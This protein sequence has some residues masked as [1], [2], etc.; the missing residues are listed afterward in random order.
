MPDDVFHCPACRAPLRR[1]PAVAAGTLAQCPR[2]DERFPVPAEDRPAPP[3][4]ADQPAITDRPGRPR[5]SA[6]DH[7]DLP[8][9]RDDYDEDQRRDGRLD[10]GPGDRPGPDENDDDYY[11]PGVPR[12]QRLNTEYQVD[13]GE[14]M[15]YAKGHWGAM[16]GPCIGYVILAYLLLVIVAVVP[17]IGAFGL[18]FM[19]PP[20]AAG[21]T[22]VALRQLQGRRWQFGD[23]FSGFDHWG[24]LV[25]NSFLTGL[26]VFVCLLPALG[27]FIFGVMLALLSRELAAVLVIGLLLCVPVLI[28]ALLRLTFFAWPL[29]IDRGYGPLEAMQG[30]WRLTAKHFWPLLGVALVCLLI[31]IGGLI[32]CGVGA[33][34]T[35]PFITLIHAAGYL[36][37]AGRRPPLRGPA[38][39]R[40]PYDS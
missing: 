9:L 14:W 13:L 6:D 16:V 32:L 29:I 30:S 37:V 4:P 22:V 18:L 36:L 3:P 26:L 28:W 33:L 15:D 17:C 5:L 25:G 40:D 24:A 7:L 11:R 2:C 27:L 23:F 20:V 19:T 12:H 10:D 21:P 34:F 35:L 38:D 8:R 1:S 39:L 31:H